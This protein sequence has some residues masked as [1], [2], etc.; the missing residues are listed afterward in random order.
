[1]GEIAATR[2][3][4]DRLVVAL[5]DQNDE[6]RRSACSALEKMGE[7]AATSQ[8]ID[9]LVVALGDLVEG[10]RGTHMKGASTLLKFW[11]HAVQWRADADATEAAG[12]Q[13]SN[14]YDGIDGVSWKIFQLLIQTRDWRWLPIFVE[15]CPKEEIVVMVTG[16][17]VIM[18]FEW[19]AEETRIGNW[20]LLSELRKAFDA[21]GSKV[22]NCR[23]QNSRI[24]CRK[25]KL[26]CSRRS[27]T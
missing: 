17:K 7:K 21:F 9:R 26:E 16:D 10:I 4:I 8:V 14:V 11:W 24:P 3:V 1:M 23:P 20:E 19:V 12:M 6:V 18:H 13:K 5:G 27:S 22:R 15:C 2:Q 25:R